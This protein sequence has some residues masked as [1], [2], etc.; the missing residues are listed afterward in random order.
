MKN[1]RNSLSG[2]DVAPYA[3]NLDH[4][5]AHV[6]VLSLRLAIEVNRRR[7]RDGSDEDFKG[8][9]VSE[10]QIDILLSRLIAPED[11][12][13]SDAI[14]QLD[15]I[16]GRRLELLRDRT[17]ISLRAGVVLRLGDLLEKFRLSEFEVGVLVLC[18]APEIDLSFE[19]I[20]AYLQDDIN[21]RR[22]SLD[23]ALTLFCGGLAERLTQRDLFLNCSSLIE[24]RLVRVGDEPHRQGGS[25]L[26]SP[27]IADVRAIDYLLG[28]EAL[29]AR[30]R[31]YGRLEPTKT[32]SRP[33]VVLAPEF[34][35]RLTDI[36]NGINA[37]T[38]TPS[39]LT[40]QLVGRQGGGKKQIARA[41]C[42]D[43]DQ[44][45]LLIDLADLLASDRPASELLETAF[46]EAVLQDAAL[47]LDG[48]HL[49]IKD[50]NANR[51][52]AATISSGLSR[53]Q[54][55]ALLLGEQ[56][57]RAEGE[58]PGRALVTLEVP[59]PDY[60]ER[61]LIWDLHLD[62]ERGSLSD[63]EVGLLAGR[64]R[65]NGGQIF[66]IASTVKDNLSLL[67]S[68]ERRLTIED[69]N[70][71]S[72]MHSNQKLA[73]LAQ[74][75]SPHYT[76]DDI[77]LPPDQK[78]QLRE[79]CSYFSNMSLVY[80]EWGFQKKTSLGKG[81]N[82]LFA[83]SSGTG[84]TMSA[85]IMAGELALDLYK[86]DL[87]GVVSKYIGETE[88][89]LDRIFREAN[90]SNSIL[91]FDEADALFGKRSEVKD[92][93]DRYAN[94]E[95]SYLLQKMEEYQGI[96]I[97]ATNFRRNMDD[98]FV[99]RMHFVIDY[100]MPEEEYRLEIWRMVFPD[101]A[102]QDASVDLDFMARQFKVTGG[103]IK[104]IAVSSAFLAAQA[105]ESIR[106]AHVIAATKREY[107]KMGKLM[108]ESDFGEYLDLV[109]SEARA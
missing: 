66:K 30:V 26:S 53:F 62:G 81:L 64:F 76:W 31:P 107:Q 12:P 80:G 79:V 59:S 75:V 54:G 27:I 1:G 57:W 40:L 32:S 88:K 85:D 16:L 36:V 48:I 18:V 93:H 28:S 86:I 42:S 24:N 101:E 96:V 47:C 39:A 71:A 38:V 37:G 46:R 63:E 2:E 89:N 15:A 78:K 61:R 51:A 77:V 55:F 25:D 49:L 41:I 104:N 87:S 82:I 50:D 84:K 106:M 10:E 70:A 90:D 65:L 23:L 19:T 34:Q 108:V 98:A 100:P 103:N 29:D 97:L 17:D 11:L 109:K 21:K 52:A 72:R 69:L 83:G 73:E 35:A 7:L 105:D 45:L 6:E 3:T 92:S 60:A 91:F 56:A 67:P 74:K 33:E 99:R 68:S 102:P 22:P 9:F 20:Y 95:V 4:I 94:I 14:Q 13:Q 44:D 58:V 5:L 43:I 8:L